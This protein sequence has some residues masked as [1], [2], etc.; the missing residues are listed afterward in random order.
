MFIQSIF[1][2][3]S[4]EDAIAQS[5]LKKN[6]T[7]LM[8]IVFRD[9]LGNDNIDD[10]EKVQNVAHRFTQTFDRV[11]WI[12]LILILLR[13][14]WMWLCWQSSQFHHQ[15]SA[16]LIQPQKNFILKIYILVTLEKTKMKKKKSANGLFSYYI[17]RAVVVT[18]LADQSLLTPEVYNSNPV[19][20]KI[21]YWAF[22]YCWNDKNQE[23]GGWEWPIFSYYI[24]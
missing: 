7:Q 24:M 15:R 14:Q 21:L 22:V 1:S 20:D 13:W 10:H 18:P 6:M 4:T 5:I 17:L 16:F 12:V 19:I 8:A 11:S 3:K 2:D 9:V 23:K